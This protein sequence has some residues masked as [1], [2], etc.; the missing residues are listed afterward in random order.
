MVVVFMR[1]SGALHTSS[2]Q[3]AR[4]VDDR[5]PTACP[6]TSIGH[7]QRDSSQGRGRIRNTRA[8]DAGQTG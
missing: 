3:D 6:T 8:V 5:L 2:E 7:V 1:G 4:L